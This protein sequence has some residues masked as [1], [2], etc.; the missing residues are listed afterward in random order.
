MHSHLLARLAL[1]CASVSLAACS[2]L[3]FGVANAPTYLSSLS[4]AQDVPY[5]PEVRQR[6]DVYAP[7]RAAHG[8]VIVFWH[9]GSWSTGNKRQYRFVGDALAKHGFVAVIPNYRLHPAVKFPAF[10]DDAALAV[11]WVRLHAS[12]YGGDPDRIVL[13]GHSAG[14]QIAT[15]L[16]YDGTY[17]KRAQVPIACIRGVIGLSG[18]YALDPDTQL[19]RTIFAQPYTHK[20]WQPLAFATAH[21]PPTLLLHGLKDDVVYARH[22]EQLREA[23]Q[24]AGVRVETQF[25]PDAGHAATVAAFA[26]AA[27]SRLPVLEHAMRFIRSLEGAPA[28][29]EQAPAS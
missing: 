3:L 18:P 6:L 24:A 13:M 12:E 9:G 1:I 26:W 5:G 21:S 22:A 8:P 4:R 16:A 19:L 15:L 10:M 7:D 11:A 20:D 2:G 25:F 28:N 29:L 14:A 23:L 27:P 17:L